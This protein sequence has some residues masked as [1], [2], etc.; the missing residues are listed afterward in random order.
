MPFTVASLAGTWG[1]HEERLVIDATGTGHLSYAD[2]TLCP[3]CSFATAPEGTLVFVLTSAS[4]GEATGRVT[5]SSDPKNSRVGQAVQVT[6][7]TGSPGQLLHLDI[8]GRGLSTFCNS[9]STGQC[10]A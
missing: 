1:A 9:T 2:L 7:T 10:G 5:A 6:L 8:G 4:N 3:S